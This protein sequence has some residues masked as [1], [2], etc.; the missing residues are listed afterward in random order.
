M[1][2]KQQDKM[3]EKNGIDETP[4]G[5]KTSSLPIHLTDDDQEKGNFQNFNI[6]KKTIKKLQGKFEHFPNQ[7]NSEI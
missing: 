7:I 6:S 3:I 4:T 1:K 5:A 2:L